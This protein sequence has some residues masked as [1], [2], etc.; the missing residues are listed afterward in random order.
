[1]KSVAIIDGSYNIYRSVF[2]G[3][4]LYSSSGVPTG[5]VFI[6]LKMLWNLKELG[7]PI[8]ILDAGHSKF[9]LQL[10]PDYKKREEKTEEE[11]DPQVDEAFS[12]AFS[13]L[14][15]L[16]PKMGIP[17]VSVEGEEADDIAYALAK[18]MLEKD[19]T[20]NIYMVSDDADWEQNVNIGATVFKA[21]KD[22]YVTLG[23]FKEKHGFDPKYFTIWK[24]LIGDGSD[25]IGGVKGVGPVSAVKIV[26]QMK[27]PDMISLHEWALS[28]DSKLHEKIRDKDNFALVKRNLLL[29]DF[30]NIQIDIDKMLLAYNTAKEEAKVNFDFVR[31]R[32]TALEFNSLQNWLVYLSQK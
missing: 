7:N 13:I 31:S 21:M 10:H 4:N 26:N 30:N 27:S 32:F 6:F 1:M 2:K 5:G 23:N 28:G 17:V 29:I 15:K 20:S 8:V 9:R 16:L 19:P 24:S 14:K 22:E 11:K 3:L 18:H 25:N 12:A